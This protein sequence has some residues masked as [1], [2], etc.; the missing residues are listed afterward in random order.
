MSPKPE[1]E[2]ELPTG[3]TKQWSR[4]QKRYFY[5]HENTKT[6]IWLV[7]EERTSIKKEL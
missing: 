1:K 3:W 6:S 7:N 5:F 2:K 4:S